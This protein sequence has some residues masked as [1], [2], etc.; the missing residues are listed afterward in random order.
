MIRSH[1]I[2]SHLVQLIVG[3]KDCPGQVLCMLVLRR[4]YLLSLHIDQTHF[5][6]FVHGRGQD[7]PK[8]QK[9]YCNSHFTFLVQVGKCMQSNKKLI[10]TRASLLVTR[11]LLY[12]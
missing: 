11:A 3:Q 1:L 7:S 12:Y 8:S 2:T 9:S 6:L 10:V 4:L 5:Y